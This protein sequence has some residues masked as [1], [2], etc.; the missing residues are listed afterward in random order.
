MYDFI[1]KWTSDVR[2]QKSFDIAINLYINQFAD[3]D[4]QK[5]L[6]KILTNL[7]FYDLNNFKNMID[8][9]RSNLE[10]MANKKTKILSLITDNIT[11]KSHAF[12]AFLQ[13]NINI[14]QINSVD[15]TFIN[16][17]KHGV[18]LI[19][20]DDYAGSLSTFEKYLNKLHNDIL[21]KI[22]KPL[23]RKI[24]ILFYPIFITNYAFERFNTIKNNYSLFNLDIKYFENIRPAKFITRGCLSKTECQKFIE[25]SE[26]L[27]IPNKYIYGFK[28]IEDTI[29]FNYFVPNN[30]LGCL[31]CKNRFYSLFQRKQGYIDVANDRN[32]SFRIKSFFKSLEVKINSKYPFFVTLL[33]CGYKKKTIIRYMN[34]S[35]NKFDKFS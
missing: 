15:Q 24:N 23:T 27:N 26:F 4:Y 9:Y 12:L 33:L 7:D 31:W 30:T 19:I 17:I 1:E 18:E 6:I 22:E 10:S 14:F 34:I 5:L 28:N 25:F 32:L 21:K 16:E 8:L 35:S 3:K 29:V 13:G 20:V 11:H 2:L